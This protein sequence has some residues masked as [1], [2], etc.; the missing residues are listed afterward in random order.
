MSYPNYNTTAAADTQVNLPPITET[1]VATDP[2]S[3]TT[4]GMYGVVDQPTYAT[5]LGY[6]DPASSMPVLPME[7]PLVRDMTNNWFGGV[8]AGIANK[9][10]ISVTLLRLLFVL[11]CLVLPGAQCIFYFIAWV[12]IPKGIGY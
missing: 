5:G 2:L 11:S 8:L 12:I 9:F 3:G 6:M 10:D 1:T 7:R 4:Y